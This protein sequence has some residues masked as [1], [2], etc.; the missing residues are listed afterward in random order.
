MPKYT[1][2]SLNPTS[3][4]SRQKPKYFE[5]RWEHSLSKG[6][7]WGTGAP[8]QSF[9]LPWYP[10]TRCQP[11]DHR[12]SVSQLQVPSST[13]SPPWYSSCS[14][15]ELSVHRIQSQLETGRGE[16]HLGESVSKCCVPPHGHQAV[17]SAIRLTKAGITWWLPVPSLFS[18][19]KKQKEYTE[20]H[21]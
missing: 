16:T 6:F 4:D 5:R 15:R 21:L 2:K 18:H 9:Q 10:G 17:L 12:P 19:E 1:E 14:A 11:W 20:K 13:G 8:P 7:R 3:W